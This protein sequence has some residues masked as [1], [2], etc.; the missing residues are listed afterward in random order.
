M[1]RT[2]CLFFL[3]AII[4]M[5]CT[6]TNKPKVVYEQDTTATG[7]NIDTTAIEMANLP[8][9]FDS[10]D[11]MLFVVGK[12][13]TYKRSSKIYI[14][15]GSSGEES[16]SVGYF[17]GTSV[18]GD[19]DNIKFQHIDSIHIR[20]LTTAQI[21]I[22]SFHL[23]HAIADVILV[24]VVD[25]DTNKDKQL[26]DDDIVS[27]YIANSNGTTFKKL[28]SNGHQLLDWKL[29]T[30]ANRIYFRTIEDVNRNGEFDKED[31]FHHYFV[32]LKTENFEAVEIFPL[33][34]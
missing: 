32:S 5:A 21:K 7:L 15:S 33:K 34:K 10:T 18:S 24:E 28:S 31:A 26:T 29:V 11:Y 2:L 6:N 14:G 25:K 23:V 22:R 1:K 8:I 3:F 20:E 27:L 16:F 19:I 30:A 12:S 9:Y 4:A 17:N 13:E